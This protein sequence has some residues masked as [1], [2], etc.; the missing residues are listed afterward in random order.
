MHHP[1]S[2]YKG[3]PFQV[4]SNLLKSIRHKLFE[5]HV[6]QCRPYG[7]SFAVKQVRAADF[8]SIITYL[9]PN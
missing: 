7:A 1:I 8:E 9:L 4:A 6:Y 3:V 2:D 5:A